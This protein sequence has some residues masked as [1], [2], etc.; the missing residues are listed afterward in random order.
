MLQHAELLIDWS[1]AVARTQPDAATDLARQALAA[2]DTA[3]DIRLLARAYTLL[4]LLARRSSNFGTAKEAG[5]AGVAAARRQADPGV[6]IAALNSLALVYAENDDFVRATH[7]IEEALTHA[8]RIGDRH[9]EA[10]L[11]NTLADLHHACGH[12]EKAMAQLKQAV[13]IFA[14]IGDDL[15][16]ENAEVWMLREW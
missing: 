2:A 3:G 8:V 11:R 13:I 4:A 6:L 9:R 1:L 16:G 10:A 12:N 14:E 15:G 7:L 5:E